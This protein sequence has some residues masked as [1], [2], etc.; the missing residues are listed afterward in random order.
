[1]STHYRM[2]IERLQQPLAMSRARVITAVARLTSG[3]RC[4]CFV[5]IEVLVTGFWRRR[6]IQVR[7]RHAIRKLQRVLPSPLPLD[8]AVVVQE[9]IMT[10]R[11]LPGCYQV[12]Q[13]LDGSRFALIR[14]ALQVDGQRLSVD[15]L[16]AVLAE[17]YIALSM[18]QSGPGL[19]VPID[20]APPRSDDARRPTVLR[21]DPLGQHRD[22]EEHDA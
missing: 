3:S 12:S 2:R 10:E 6:S 13:R 1:M 5:P 18:Q 9:I 20:L 19:L 21:P 14:L 8:V 4:D 22:F 16:L 15:E 11:Q 17:Q 7:L